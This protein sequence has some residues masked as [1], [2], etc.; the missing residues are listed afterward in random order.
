MEFL[1][2]MQGQSQGTFFYDIAIELK[3]ICCLIEK[4]KVWKIGDRVVVILLHCIYLDVW[5]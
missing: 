2:D 3:K 1:I 4:A 5:N